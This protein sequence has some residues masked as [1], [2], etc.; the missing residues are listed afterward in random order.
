MAQTLVTVSTRGQGLYEFTEAAAT[1][2][3]Q[4]GAQEGL[5]TIFVR[6]TSCSLIIQE[7][8]DPDVKRDL[9]AFFARLVPPSSDPSMAYL[10][11][12]LEGQD[13]MP[14]H[15]KAALTATSIGIPVSRGRL[16]LGTWQGIYL[17]EHRDSPHRREIVLHLSA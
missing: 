6:H 3:A 10:V 13:D 4:T 8:A 14:A 12:T 9:K 7:N 15:I 5:L 16:M 17:F 1:F 2:I 11:H